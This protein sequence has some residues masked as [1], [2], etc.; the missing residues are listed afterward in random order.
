MKLRSLVLAGFAACIAITAGLA[1][2]TIST[3]AKQAAPLETIEGKADLTSNQGIPLLLALKDMRYDIVQVQQFLTDV[4][5]TGNGEGFGEAEEFARHFAEDLATARDLA[6]QL[7][8]DEL[9]RTLAGMEELFRQYYAAG[10]S[11]AEAYV[12]DGQE[13]GNVKMEAFDASAKALSERMD[14]ASSSVNDFAWA[15]MGELLEQTHTVRAA[16]DSLQT[17]LLVTCLIGIIINLVI[18]LLIGAYASRLFGR[19]QNDVSAVLDERGDVLELDGNRRDEFGPIA[20]ALALFRSKSGEVKALEEARQRHE[21]AAEA[22]RR[23]ALLSMADAVEIETASAVEAVASEG[24]RVSSSAAAMADSAH[25]VGEHSQ[26]VAAAAEQ[27]LRNAQ[28]VAGAS[29]ELSASIQEIARQVDH[30]NEAVERVVV[31]ATKAAGIVASLTGAMDKI[32]DV[33]SMIAE[34]AQHTNLLALNATIEAARAGEAGKGFAVVA[35][36]VKTLA[37]QTSKSTEEI[38][39]QVTTLQSV[40]RDV[41]ACIEGMINT[42]QDV[43][44]MS[45]SIAAAVRQQDSATREITRNVVETSAAAQEVSSHIATV[46]AEA[47]STGQHA[48]EV[49]ELLHHMAGRIRDLRVAV[50]SAVRSATPEVNRRRNPRVHLDQKAAVELGGQVIEANLA[51]ISLCGGRLT[52]VPEHIAGSD[53]ALQVEGLGVRIPCHVVEMG[54]GNA[55]LRFAEDRAPAGELS[56]FI[57]ERSRERRDVA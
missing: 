45:A 40:G 46:A 52:A 47:S 26:A 13:A 48:V 7:K 42:V 21:A 20:R 12:K 8:L 55:Q 19:L 24:D 11:M 41:A 44:G 54:E 9:S 51:D 17:T 10:R 31:Q 6:T 32:G 36:E 14:V 30:S 33:A 35:G 5:A 2:V 23:A 39:R 29:E 15:A 1:G 38:S 53:G 43:E 56:R 49:R 28:T 27:A 34:I 18:A 3:I 16:N 25:S 4:S 50:N 22:S 57:A 37:N